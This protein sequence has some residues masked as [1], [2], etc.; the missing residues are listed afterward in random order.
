M[1]TEENR[2]QNHHTDLGSD[3]IKSCND[4]LHIAIFN[5]ENHFCYHIVQLQKLHSSPKLNAVLKDIFPVIPELTTPNDDLIQFIMYPFIVYSHINRNN[6]NEIYKRIS[7][8]Y[9]TLDNYVTDYAKSGFNPDNLLICIL[10]PSLFKIINDRDLFITIINELSLNIANL[11]IADY[12]VNNNITCNDGFLKGP[13]HE[14]LLKNY[15]EMKSL[16]IK[17]SDCPT[18]DQQNIACSVLEVFPIPNSTKNGHAVSLFFGTTFGPCDFVGTLG[19]SVNSNTNTNGSGMSIN[20]NNSFIACDSINIAD[21]KEYINERRDGINRIIIRHISKEFINK[22][23]N[24][25]Q[26]LKFEQTVTSYT[27]KIDNVKTLSGGS[28][29]K[30]QKHKHR[31]ESKN[32]SSSGSEY[33]VQYRPFCG[34]LDFQSSREQIGGNQTQKSE[35]RRSLLRDHIIISKMSYY[36]I[37]VL[38][39]VGVIAVLFTVYIGYTVYHVSNHVRESFKTYDHKMTIDPDT[40][41]WKHVISRKSTVESLQNSNTN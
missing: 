24:Y 40:K 41:Q 13:F 31:S 2:W 28:N 29:R 4:T 33:R 6:V 23:N 26:N 19:S 14:E 5:T 18:L 21:L 3:I 22:L 1:T 9:E 8:Y 11:N 36:I 12:A 38:A 32:S 34:S 17:H 20:Q 16:N 39:F 25:L 10:L 35:H 30:H 37:L 7:R 15:I 27:L